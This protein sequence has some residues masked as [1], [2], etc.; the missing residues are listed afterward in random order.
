MIDLD[1]DR[2]RDDPWY[3]LKVVRGHDPDCAVH[4]AAWGRL[5]D[6]SCVGCLVLQLQQDG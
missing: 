4:P 5:F 6:E 2:A 1:L 3:V